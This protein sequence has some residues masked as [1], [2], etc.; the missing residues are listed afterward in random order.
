M[1][2]DRSWCRSAPALVLMAAA[3]ALM[4]VAVEAREHGWLGLHRYG[5]APGGLNWAQ[6]MPRKEALLYATLLWLVPLA[7]AAGLWL[8]C[9]PWW[10]RMTTVLAWRWRRTA[11]AAAALAA[12]AAFAGSHLV[13]ERTPLTDDEHAYLFQARIFSL[14][15]LTWESPPCRELFD[16]TFLVNDGRWYSQYPAGHPLLLVP[17]VWLGD[18]WIVPAACAGFSVFFMAAAARRLHGRSAAA[19]T[20]LLA[21]GSPFLLGI[22][23]TLLSHATCLALLAAFLWAGLLATRPGSYW[24]WGLAAALLFGLAVLDRPFSAVAV[25]APLT[26]LLLVRW[27][28]SGRRRS[29][30][31]AYGAGGLAMLALQLW[32]DWRMNGHP[33]YTGY[34]AYWLPREGWRSPFG[35]GTFPWGIVHTP[36]IALG[37][38]WHGLVRLNAW[39]L[40]WPVSLVAVAAGAAWLGRRRGTPWLLAA[41]LFSPAAYTFYFWPGIADVGPVLLGETMAAL[42]PL[43]GAGIGAAPRRIRPFAAGFA[44][45]SLL[46]AAAAFHRP[47]VVQLRATA[48]N[49]R[50]PFAEVV[51]EIP[52]RAVVLVPPRAGVQ[53]CWVAGRPNPW[54]DLRDR[55]IFLADPG[56][57]DA[58]ARA[59]ACCPG[60][61]VYLLRRD[62]RGGGRPIPW[63]G[64][65]NGPPGG[66]P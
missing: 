16:N 14:G 12:L 46:L 61:T 8:A 38:L 35:F 50:A 21:A 29:L 22:S 18:P 51:R 44:A 36:A 65:T 55:V 48:A 1:G 28:R 45:A 15:R 33:L 57:P 2:A 52:G 42:L 6:L 47:Q 3:P 49:A 60:R 11:A 9:R 40:G 13:L 27:W 39:L 31:A 23:S 10:R 19:W 56:G 5:A 63:G 17:G 62:G 53:R 26:G 34:V 66:G 41:G 24:G 7:L 64:E 54:P 37:N 4:F 59:A 32:L 43:A 25:G 20:A 30:A 58:P